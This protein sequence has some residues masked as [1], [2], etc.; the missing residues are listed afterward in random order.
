MLGIG[1][2]MKCIF[3]SLNQLNGFVVAALSGRA[4]CA[5]HSQFI[6]RIVDSGRHANG[7]MTSSPFSVL[8]KFES[9]Q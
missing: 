2:F 7:Y 5:I 8:Y 1:S 4:S 9:P 6:H 3:F